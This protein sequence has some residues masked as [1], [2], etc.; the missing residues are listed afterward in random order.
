MINNTESAICSLAG[1]DSGKLEKLTDTEY[2]DLLSLSITAS[3]ERETPTMLFLATLNALNHSVVCADL[4]Y[5]SPEL[6]KKRDEYRSYYE[7][8]KPDEYKEL[9]WWSE[10]TSGLDMAVE[11]AQTHDWLAEDATRESEAIASY[12]A[13]MHLMERDIQE[14]QDNLIQTKIDAEELSWNDMSGWVATCPAHGD[15]T[16]SL[17]IQET[18]DGQ[19]AIRCKV[20]CTIKSVLGALG[21]EQ[22]DLCAAE[23]IPDR[24]KIEEVYSY[25][26]NEGNEIYQMVYFDD[27]LPGYTRKQDSDGNWMWYEPEAS[28]MV[29]YNLHNVK[30][31]IIR[32]N[33]V[34]FLVDSEADVEAFRKIGAVATCNRYGDA[35]NW[36]ES[37]TGASVVVLTA[38]T[39]SK[40]YMRLYAEIAAEDLIGH[41]KSIKIVELPSGMVGSVEAWINAGG[42]AE[43]L[44]QLV[45][46][47]KQWKKKPKVVKRTVNNTE[48]PT[49]VYSP[50]YNA[51]KFHKVHGANVRYCADDD[52]WYIWTGQIWR[53]DETSVVKRMMLDSI[54]NLYKE[55]IALGKTEA[56][57]L[58]RHIKASESE[59]GI[60][61]ALDVLKLLDNVIIR[62]DVLDS[63][64]WLL[65]ASNG[66]INLQTGKLLPFNR[67]DMITVQIKSRFDPNA[68]CPRFD[69]YLEEILPND[70]GTQV[71]IQ[72]FAGYLTTGNA[73]LRN[74]F[75]LYGKAGTGKSIFTETLASILGDHAS[76]M[77]KSALVQNPH[78][79]GNDRS[80][81]AALWQK[82]MVTVSEFSS[83][84]RL[85]EDLLKTLTGSDT[86]SVRHL[87]GRPFAVRPRFKMLFATNFIPKFK[88]VDSAMRDRLRIIPFIQRFYPVSE[89]RVPVRDLGL[90]SRLETEASGILAW[91]VRGC[92]DYQKNGIA[93]SKTVK[94]CT[95]SCFEEQ[96]SLSEYL[97]SCCRFDIR[98]STPLKTLW[99]SLDEYC[100]QTARKLPVQD[101]RGLKQNLQSRDG[102]VFRKN[103]S[104]AILCEGIEL[105][106]NENA[107]GEEGK[108]SF[109][110]SSSYVYSKDKFGELPPL[111]SSPSA[112]DMLGIEYDDSD[113]VTVG[114]EQS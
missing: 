92:L 70:P 39:D 11:D 100:E 105:L 9:D 93:E 35:G 18:P 94:E 90:T 22:E 4:A 81:I 84:E 8:N 32:N 104:G 64:P 69:Q 2:T 60:R 20:G 27:R 62:A 65:S 5:T 6:T 66:T 73:D 108:G 17:H 33:V 14:M 98:A 42:S 88:S 63:N 61:G 40:P 36:L 37:L 58:L 47:Q 107:E 97:Q 109:S 44:K 102:V 59:P 38:N 1:S 74:C 43:E 45:R 110:Q 96:D 55:L 53:Q 10:D 16:K 87:Y 101:S 13:T 23:A 12:V 57:T 50:K 31:A 49:T 7:T 28:G 71:Y 85:D 21:L 91:I 89:Q 111:P 54:Q 41:A 106:S 79:G 29:L 67:D 68:K 114:I 103:R 82:R 52:R 30:Q 83:G 78:G 46:K 51:A 99:K 48:I 24:P 77:L 15:E 26:D 76:P 112:L 95:D 3:T 34:V 75:I 19:C 25:T 80:A 113:Y 72:R 56:D 86:I